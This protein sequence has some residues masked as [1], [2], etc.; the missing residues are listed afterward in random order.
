MNSWVYEAFDR[1]AAF[2]LLPSQSAGLRPWTRAECRRQMMEAGEQV[3]DIRHSRDAGLLE[4]A[5]SLL[6]A[7]HRELDGIDTEGT[8]VVLDSVY[9]MNGVIAGPALNDSYHFGETWSN[10]FGRPFGRGWNSYDGFQAHAESG[11]FFAYIDGEYQRAP[12]QPAYSLAT[13]ET[14]AAADGNPLQNAVPETDTSR[15]RTV[16][17]YAGVRVGDFE[18]SV[19]KQELYWGPTY[20]AP[21]SFSQNAEPT[22]NARLS[23]VHPIELPGI[24]RYLG[25]IR[26]EIVL[27][28]LG[29]E[30]YTWRPWFNA[31]KISFK[32]TPNLEMGF[33][34]WS[35]MWGVGF[36]ITLGSLWS[37]LTTISSR[38]SAQPNYTGEVKGGFD[39]RYRIPGLRNWLTLYSDSWS[40]DDPSPL[41]APRRAAVE[42]GIYV[43]HVPGLAKLDFRVEAPSTM[44]MRGDYGGQFDYYNGQYHSSNTNYGY[45]IGNPVGRD[46]RAIEGWSTYHFSARSSM[47]AGYRQLKIG[48]RFLPGGGTQT[49]ATL[50]GSMRLPHQFVAA[51]MFQYERFWIPVLGGEARNLSATLQITWEPKLKLFH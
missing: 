8:Q 46:G 27:G 29:G 26:A 36:P 7:L 34:R 44:L 10:N 4:Q 23:T 28:K 45:L 13:R 22:K 35:E 6:E 42:P 3:D 47:Q 32:L 31:Q 17:A 11:R 30:S 16:E 19:G 5:R 40:D 41:A 9:T 14:I 50:K 37:N 15:F 1:L 33:T 49:D 38:N 51:A 18:F 48:A 39:F 2:G 25:E 24:L 43:S 21:L 12:G 20:D